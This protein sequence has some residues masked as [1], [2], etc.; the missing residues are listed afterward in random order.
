MSRAAAAL[1]LL[2]WLGL[3]ALIHHLHDTTP[4]EEGT[5]V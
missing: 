3:Q 5:N 4:P 2:T 1:V